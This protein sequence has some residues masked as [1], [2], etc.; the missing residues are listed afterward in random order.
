MR[1]KIAVYQGTFDP[2]T[3]G[4][5]E[6]A[7]DALSIFD[8]VIILLLVNPVKKPL[9]SVEERKEMIL[10]TIQTLDGVSVDSYQGLLADYMKEKGLTCC[11]RGIRNER[12]YAYELENHQLSK[13]FY[14]DLKTFFLP[15][16]PLWANVSSGAVK[17][18]CAYGSL[19]ATWVSSAVVQNLLQKFPKIKLVK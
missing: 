9:F 16:D 14:P 5:L 17:A 8:E 15:C 7:K 4:H 6:V 1:K 10:Q 3:N 13:V 12:D 2:F 11:V 19:P 18:A